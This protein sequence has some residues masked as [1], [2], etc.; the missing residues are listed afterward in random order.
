MSFVSTEFGFSSDVVK[1]DVRATY[2]NGKWGHS[3]HV[4]TEAGIVEVY[5]SPKG[6]KLRVFLG[7]KELKP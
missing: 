6:K 1:M 5:L 7:G 2:S 3:V 4:T